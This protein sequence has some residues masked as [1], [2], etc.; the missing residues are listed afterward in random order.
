MIRKGLNNPN[1]TPEL[2]DLENEWS[3]INPYVSVLSNKTNG[4]KRNK[5]RSTHK[6]FCK[7]NTRYDAAVFWFFCTII[8]NSGIR[9]SELVKLRHKDIS[10]VKDKVSGKYFTLLNI[11]SSVS[12]VKKYRSAICRDFHTSYERYLIYKKEK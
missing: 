1:W 7:K 9:P 12:K 2:K 3:E 11:S 5:N 10:L 4:N 6:V 8:S